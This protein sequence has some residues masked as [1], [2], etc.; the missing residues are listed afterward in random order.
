MSENKYSRRPLGDDVE[1]DYQ[2]MNE[3]FR[4]AM[5]IA[6]RRMRERVHV[7]IMKDDSAFPGRMMQP[8]PMYSPCGSSAARCAE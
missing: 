2:A 1:F 5:L 4:D 7:G 3:K 6:K 8:E